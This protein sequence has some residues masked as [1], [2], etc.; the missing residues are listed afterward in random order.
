MTDT[1]PGLTLGPLDPD[2]SSDLTKNLGVH[3]RATQLLKRHA[4]NWPLELTRALSRPLDEMRTEALD[5]DEVLGALTALKGRRAFFNEDTDELE[6]AAVRGIS[7]KDLIVSVVYRRGGEFGRLAQGVIPYS[8]MSASQRAYDELKAKED[9][10][11]L[12][13]SPASGDPDALQAA[14]AQVEAAQAAQASAEQVAR[15]SRAAQEAMEER[16][17]RL[18]NPEPFPGYDDL[19]ARERADRIKSGG[20]DE[21][22]RAGLERIHAYEADRKQPSK[23]VLAAIEDALAST[24]PPAD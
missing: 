22:G 5:H 13:A 7:E 4:A 21:F 16:L 17:R 6:D 24:P 20:V 23:Q 11:P 3:N 1:A 19:D 9:G 14:Q 12:A 15:E 2:S 18:E 10:T 8:G